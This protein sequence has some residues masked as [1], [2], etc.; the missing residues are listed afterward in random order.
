VPPYLI[1]CDFDG[2]ITRADTLHLIIDAF[3]DRGVWDAL[4]PDL[5]AGRMS[6]EQAMETEFA[7]VRAT[8][9]EVREMVRARAGI[10]DGFPEFVSW[11]RAEGHRVEVFSNGF[12]SVIGDLLERAGLGDLPFHSHDIRFGPEGARIL[13]SA[14]G[15]R[16]TLCA[17]PCKRHDLAG[18]GHRGPVAYVGDGISDRC[19]AGAADLVFARDGLAEWRRGRGEDFVPYEDF[20][21]V[22]AGLEAHAARRERAA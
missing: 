20:H 16:C 19:V 3:G 18:I 7:T 5:R 8:P 13:W 10:R 4:E 1:A 22:R 12:A 2:T 6:L 15:E 11:A 17:R 21:A 14:R 9:E